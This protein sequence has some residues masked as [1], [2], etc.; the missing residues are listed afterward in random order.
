M[1]T[2]GPPSIPIIN[3][4]D[5]MGGT[6]TTRKQVA[7]QIDL[8]LQHDGFLYI[9]DH[10]ID[11]ELVQAAFEMAYD[12]AS[13]VP[14]TTSASQHGFSP[15]GNSN[16]EGSAALNE[17]FSFFTPK[18]S[19]EYWSPDGALP[20]F[21]D[22]MVRFHED[23]VGGLEIADVQGDNDQPRSK[24][25]DP[26][27]GTIVVNVGHLLYRWTNKRWKSTEHRVL[28]PMDSFSS[29]RTAGTQA[30]TLLPDRYSIGFFATPDYDVW[31]EPLP[32]CVD[33]ER[34]F[35]FL[36]MNVGEFVRRKEKTMYKS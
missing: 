24:S 22:I 16:V 6:D 23:D 28:D 14:I 26:I 21:K 35:S 2:D 1:S 7:A 10:G 27:P 15:L 25:V 31:I 5:F 29:R 11:P 36:P 30:A 32:G 13:L 4:G 18:D 20:G 3:L 33:A 17:S 8:A 34:P 19:D 12:L 9:K